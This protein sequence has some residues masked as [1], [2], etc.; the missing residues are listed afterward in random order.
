MKEIEVKV[1]VSPDIKAWDPDK[2]VFFDCDLTPAYSTEGSAGMDF[3]A[4]IESPVRINPG[5]RT[6]IPTGVRMELPEGYELQVRPRSGMARNYG[7][8]VLNT[9]GTIDSDFRGEIGVILINHSTEDYTIFPGTKIA[10]GVVKEYVKARLIRTDKVDRNTDRGEG[11]Y[12]S[13]GSI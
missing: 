9:P 8:T 1:E 4:N 13:T 11:G 12:G 6:T 7:I 5:Q 10:Q 3:R 2:E